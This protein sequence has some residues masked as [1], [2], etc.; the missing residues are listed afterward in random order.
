MSI[1]TQIIN[2]QA[3][4]GDAF[5]ALAEAVR[6][7][8]VQVRG[9]GP[10]GGSGIIWRADGLIITNAH[11]AQGTRAE[12]E[13]ADGRVFPAEVIARDERRD[14]AALQI[15]ATDLPAASIGNSDALRVGELVLAVGNP[16]GLVGAASAGIIHTLHAYVSGPRRQQWIQA[17]VTLAPGNSGGPLVT[18][19]GEVIGVNSMIAGGLGLAVPS[20]AVERF[21]RRQSRRPSLGVTVQPVALPQGESQV[22]GLLLVEVTPDGSAAQ[23]GIM[24][25]DVLTGID[26]HPL[27]SPDDL[28]TS[29]SEIDLGETLTIDLLHGGTP[30]SVKVTLLPAPDSGADAVAA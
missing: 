3:R 9:E 8:T 5:V 28:L 29:I 21:L 23:A 1:A 26:G 12:V 11:V 22:L 15:Q 19:R 27:T 16:L 20:N 2:S 30:T 7:V 14:L 25:G 17:D 6:R 4:V 18:A 13:L 24:I 10:G